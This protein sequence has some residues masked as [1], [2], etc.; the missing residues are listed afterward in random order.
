MSKHCSPLLSGRLLLALCSFLSALSASAE[1]VFIDPS[2]IDVATILPPPPDDTSH[3]GRA[4]HSTS[5]EPRSPSRK[6]P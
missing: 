6:C 3:A 2:G 1:A 5:F 4:W